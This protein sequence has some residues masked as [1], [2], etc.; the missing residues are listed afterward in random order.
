MHRMNM[1]HDRGARPGVQPHPRFRAGGPHPGADYMGFL[2]GPA[3]GPRGF[4]GRAR[5]GDVRSAILSLLGEGP[6]NGYGLIKAIHAKSD[7]AWRPSPGSVYPTLQQLV[8]EGLIAPTS[9]GPRAEYDLTDEGRAYVA[10]HADEIAAAWTQSRNPWKEQG[11]LMTA[12]RKLA[13]VVRQVAAEGTTEQRA[14][15]SAKLDD[16]RREL[17]RM[18]GE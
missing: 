5:K 2:G 8:D 9:Q 6:T 13:G 1:N 18:L 12:A 10:D 15:A 4:G 16:L 7:G 11:D 3:F 14:S 17:Y